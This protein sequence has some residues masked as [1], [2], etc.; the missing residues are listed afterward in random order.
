MFTIALLT[1]EQAKIGV[2][3]GRHVLVLIVFF[4]LLSSLTALVHASQTIS[5]PPVSQQTVKVNLSQG[6]SVNGT[7][8][9]IGGTGTGVD[10]TV[11]DP[12]GKE[13]LSYNWTSR[14]N[15]SFSA[16]INGTY[17]LLFDNSFCSCYGGKTVTLNYSVNNKTDQ[18]N[19]QSGSSQEFPIATIVIAVSV[20]VVI[21]IFSVVI[22]IRRQRTAKHSRT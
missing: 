16:S 4:V 15:F 14:A 3:V 11:T 17:I 6:D 5:V 2:F 18:V 19:T 20:V 21:A 13:L 22:V 10:F 12:N 8:S 7:F 9:V 1:I